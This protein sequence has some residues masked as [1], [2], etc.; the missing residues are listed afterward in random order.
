M[1]LFSP[2]ALTSILLRGASLR[3]VLAGAVSCAALGPAASRT[4]AER[5]GRTA[6]ERR[7]PGCV[8]EACCRQP[9]Q[10]PP[11][12]SPAGLCGS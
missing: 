6:A 4:L 8:A 10:H 7:L 11:A 2:L 9:L 5:R 1:L 3:V 12:G